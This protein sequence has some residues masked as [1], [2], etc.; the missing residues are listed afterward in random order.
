MENIPRVF[1]YQNGKP[2][3]EVVDYIPPKRN[4]IQKI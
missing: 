4:S 3:E 2:D 1:N